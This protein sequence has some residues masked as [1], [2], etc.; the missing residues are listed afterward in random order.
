[1][2]HVNLPNL[3]DSRCSSW[4]AWAGKPEILQRV[5][6]TKLTLPLLLQSGENKPRKTRITTKIDMK[7]VN[8]TIKSDDIIYEVTLK[9][10]ATVI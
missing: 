10:L 6:T 4:L 2:G 8:L 9:Y 7:Q 1:M 3:S 5:N